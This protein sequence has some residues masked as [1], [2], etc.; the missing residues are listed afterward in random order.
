LC[1]FV[2]KRYEKQATYTQAKTV[3]VEEGWHSCSNDF[4]KIAG[5]EW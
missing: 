1:W 4:R 2:Q 5:T 3:N